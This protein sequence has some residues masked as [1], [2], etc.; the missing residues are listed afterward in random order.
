[1][2]RRIVFE[3]DGAGPVR[4]AVRPTARVLP[5]SARRSAGVITAGSRGVSIAQ[6]GLIEWMHDG[7]AN[8]LDYDAMIALRVASRSVPSH[9]C[10]WHGYCAT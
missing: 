1:D 2:A 8:P 9:G 3:F 10:F 4:H 6:S 7:A 5:I